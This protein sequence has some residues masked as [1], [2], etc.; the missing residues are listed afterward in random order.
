M[1]KKIKARANW[2]N[3]YIKTKDAGYVCHKCGVSR[4]TLRKWYRHYQQEGVQGLIEQSKK[5]HSSPNQKINDERTKIILELREHR[6]LGTRRIQTELTRIFH[7]GS[8]ESLNYPLKF[9][10]LEKNQDDFHH[11]KV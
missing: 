11:D 6:N 2:V 4:P 10:L 7:Q 3:L 8:G 5:P 1:D 9:S